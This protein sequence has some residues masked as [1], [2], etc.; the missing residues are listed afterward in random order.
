MT[1]LGRRFAGLAPLRLV[2]RDRGR[3]TRALAFERIGTRAQLAGAGSQAERAAEGI[4][5]RAGDDMA[6]KSIGILE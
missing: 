6:L 2:Q 5:G 3:E 4:S 1:H